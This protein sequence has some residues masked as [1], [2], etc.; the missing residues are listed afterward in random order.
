MENIM[1]KMV[2]EL[3]DETFRTEVTEGEGLVFVDFWAPWC[4]P[5]RMVA[6]VVERLA[7]KYEGRV[8]FT[9]VNVDEAQQ[10][11]AMFGIASIP[12]LALFRDGEPVTG[13][14]GAVPEH[15]LAAMIDQELTAS[16][17]SAV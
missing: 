7:E 13:V 10:T 15:H 6:P 17:G 16:H 9:K 5:C 12:T 1:S 8:R 11:A 14:A 3:T 2:T 4:A